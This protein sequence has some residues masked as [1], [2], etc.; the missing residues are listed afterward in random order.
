VFEEKVQKAVNPELKLSK[1]GK[2]ITIEK[3]SLPYFVIKASVLGD[4]SSFIASTNL[5]SANK[6]E[7]K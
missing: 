1:E 4:L 6:R 2:Q 7:Q 3:G 5:P